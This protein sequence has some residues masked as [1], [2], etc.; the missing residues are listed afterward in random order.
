MAVVNDGISVR[1]SS[2]EYNVPKSTLHDRITGRVAFGSHSGPTRYLSEAE[3]KELVV[4]LLGCASLGYPRSCKEIIGLVQKVMF[5]KGQKVK[6]T[7]GWWNSFRKRH[8]NLTLRNPEP[9]AHARAVCCSDD[10]INRY[11][12]LFEQT[13]ED[14]GIA[15]KPCQLFNC[16]ESGF[17]LNPS[18]PK[19]IVAKGEK[20]PY[21]ITTGDKSQITVLSCCSAG[22]YVMPPLVVF[23]RKSLKP[24]MTVGEVPGTMYGLSDSGWMD[25]E[26]FDNWFRHHFL[27]YAPPVRP[28]LLLLDGHSS[29]YTP[30]LISK[31]LEEGVIIFCL[32]PHSTHLTQPLDS[33]A[34]SSLKS[35]WKDECHKFML[36]NPGKVVS[37]YTFS[38]VFSKAW[39]HAMTMQNIITSFRITGLYPVDRNS[40]IQSSIPPKLVAEDVKKKTGISF[41]P[42]YTQ[43]PSV[44]RCST[45][46]LSFSEEEM[47]RYQRRYEEGYDIT[48]DEKYNKWVKMYHPDHSVQDIAVLPNTT[49]LSKL[50]VNNEPKI[51]LPQKETRTTA[52]ILT[53][54]ESYKILKEKEKKKQEAAAKKLENQRKKQGNVKKGKR[55]G[56][57]LTI[58]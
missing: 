14:N 25:G 20:H 58:L 19:V 7:T 57:N 24:E 52:R 43:S 44:K 32:P 46:N 50:I 6:V 2:T 26:L 48:S 22:G 16:D 45:L 39:V 3:E 41:V 55:T 37:R 18:P 35:C 21:C 9:L 17:P 11:F 29:H 1:Q 34:F 42:L 28:V 10:V 33:C 47:F 56:T 51:K 54:E 27:T 40:V 53:S 49:V 4:F 30:S 13:L 38:Q 5:E 36:S 31:A 15:D 8:P 23:D 12:D